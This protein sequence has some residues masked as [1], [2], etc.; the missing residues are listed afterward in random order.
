MKLE[1]DQALKK[2]MAMLNIQVLHTDSSGTGL[3]QFD[4]G[5]RKSLDPFFNFAEFGHILHQNIPSYTLMV[6]K[7]SFGV[8]YALFRLPDEED[9]FYMLGP[10]AVDGELKGPMDRLIK[11]MPEQSKQAVVEYYSAIQNVTAKGEL[12]MSVVYALLNSM[13]LKQP[14]VIE[15]YEEFLPMNFR[16]DVRSYE[17]PSFSRDMPYTLLEERYDM[18]NTMLEAVMRGDTDNAIIA[19]N[20]MRRFNFHGRFTGSL[21][22]HKAKLVIFNT[23]LRKA[24][25]QAQVHPYYIDRISEQFAKRIESMTEE[26]ESGLMIDMIKEYCG[27]VQKY[28]LVNYS[29]V[30][31][32]VINYINLNLEAELSLK[33]LSALCFISPSYLSNL[34]RQETG[35]TLTNYINT[36]RIQRA[37][38]YLKRTDLSI[39][40]VSSKVGVLD[41][42][43]F[44]KIFRKAT[45]ETP[46]QYRVRERNLMSDKSKKEQK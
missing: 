43:Y 44:T 36:I 2:M 21:Y 28:S 34:F 33:T 20:Q 8:R 41:V 38:Y 42:N 1:F 29:P 35:E 11:A 3:D 22:A 7:D 46:T 15:E 31:Q 32:K 39:A 37:Q 13:E 23:M 16:P 9:G 12:A 6:T 19:F 4:Y 45:E 25:Q 18:E 14:Y 17:A 40:A 5:L 24:I 27:Y 30:I 26:D 10:W